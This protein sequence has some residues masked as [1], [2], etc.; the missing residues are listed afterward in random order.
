MNPPFTCI[1]HR[2]EIVGEAGM[3]SQIDIIEA[4]DD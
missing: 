2:T 3:E 4:K 1:N